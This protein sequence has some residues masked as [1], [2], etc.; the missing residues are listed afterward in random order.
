MEKAESHPEE[1]LSDVVYSKD[2]PVIHLELKQLVGQGTFGSVYEALNKKT[3]EILAVKIM[4]ISGTDID[5]LRKEILVIKECE[6]K[7]LIKFHGSYFKEGELWLVMEYCNGGSVSDII[8]ST[9]KPLNEDQISGILKQV[10]RGLDY[11]HRNRKIHRDVK[12]GNILLNSQGQAKLGDFGVCAELSTTISKKTT[13]AGSPFW[14]SPEVI[15]KSEYNKKTD[16]WSLGITAIEMA[17]GEP[18]YYH[19]HPIRAMFVIEN[20][21]ASGL[22]DPTQWSSE[23]NSFVTMCL[24]IDPKHRPTAAEL[25][26]HPFILKNKGRETVTKLV[27]E[28]LV[29]LQAA[30]KSIEDRTIENKQSESKNE[31]LPD[32]GNIDSEPTGTLIIKNVNEDPNFMGYIRNMDLEFDSK[33]YLK[34]HFDDNKEDLIKYGNAVN[35]ARPAEMPLEYEGY[36][37]TRLEQIL[38]RLNTDMEA[39]IET[40]KMRYQ[41]KINKLKTAIEILD[42]ERGVEGTRIIGNEE[43][44]EILKINEASAPVLLPK[45]RIKGDGTLPMS[46]DKL[47]IKAVERKK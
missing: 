21:P 2:D 18:P 25:L 11:M 5:T 9:K 23:F 26:A 15:K 16:I 47:T 38:E 33:K 19:I 29:S 36:T 46:Y 44:K 34:K 8:K 12:A 14:M 40:I 35:N 41:G 24:Q 27:K 1:I 32:G 4:P 20:K 10:L 30:R 37:K 45:H 3:G 6:N 7:Y 13:R 22:T 42:N 43:R 28:S 31:A 17:E 39:E